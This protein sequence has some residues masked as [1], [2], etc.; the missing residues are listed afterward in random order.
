MAGA[1]GR[2]GVFSRSVLLASLAEGLPHVVQDGKSVGGHTTLGF[3]SMILHIQMPMWKGF[4]CV[5]NLEL[6]P[7][8]LYTEI[9]FKLH[10]FVFAQNQTQ[11]T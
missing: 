5:H 7:N 2:T 6:T 11:C 4:W 3:C 9:C 8:A 1:L 10:S